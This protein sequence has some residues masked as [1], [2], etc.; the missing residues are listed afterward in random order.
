MHATQIDTVTN[1]DVRG[2]GD[3]L[4]IT[5][6][7]EPRVVDFY[8]SMGSP[9]FGAVVS[10]C[11][12]NVPTSSTYFWPGMASRPTVVTLVGEL[13]LSTVPL[14]RQCFAHIDGDIDVDCSGLD[15]VDPRGLGILVSASER[16]ERADAKFVLVDPTGA[17]LRLLRI[18]GLDTRVEVRPDSTLV[19]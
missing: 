15:H 12:T 7:H 9:F 6:T 14:L 2:V 13:D 5:D 10:A 18:S 17:M 19:G 4:A 3:V 11:G 1:R 16:C 8:R